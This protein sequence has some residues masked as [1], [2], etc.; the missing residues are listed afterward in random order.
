M[1]KALLIT[2][3]AACA[4]LTACAS[5]QPVRYSGLASS[6]QLQA[7]RGGKSGRIP[8]AYSPQVDWRQYRSVVVE[9][10]TIYRGPD[11]QF[12]KI[13]EV[14][15]QRLADYMREQFTESLGRDLRVVDRPTRDA[16]RVRLTLTGAKTT[17]AVL[18]TVLHFDLAG[19]PYNAVQ[20]ARGKE[21]MMMG[22]VMYA[23]EIEDASSGQLLN[24]YVAKQYP[25]AMNVKASVGALAASM[26]GVR[27]GADELAEKL[28]PGRS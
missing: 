27:K 21:G 6:G 17:T 23:V 24:A 14:N 28:N 5:A 13:S 1:R 20:G 25:N 19:G 8:Y 3:L 11:S 10:V 18:G 12:E 9:P 26:A 7:E 2:S 16:I 4:T 15:K 22:S